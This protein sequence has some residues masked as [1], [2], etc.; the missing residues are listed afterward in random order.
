MQEQQHGGADRRDADRRRRVRSRRRRPAPPQPPPS[1]RGRGDR[2]DEEADDAEAEVDAEHA[3]HERE[4][5]R[6][7]ARRHDAGHVREPAAGGELTRRPRQAEQRQQ[8]ES[9]HEHQHV[10]G[11]EAGEPDRHRPA[12]RETKTTCLPSRALTV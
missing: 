9:E 11:R 6:E 5:R 7:H 2:G 8:P 12:I 4:V 10:R 3:G 1:G